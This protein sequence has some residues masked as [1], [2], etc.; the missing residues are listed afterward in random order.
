MNLNKK[1]GLGFGS[2]L[3]VLGGLV[4]F[5]QSTLASLRDGYDGMIGGEL[6]LQNDL[7]TAE[8]LMLQ[9]RRNEKDFLLRYDEK[10][11]QEFSDSLDA[12]ID[13][14]S[15]MKV[16]AQEI[17]FPE[18]VPKAKLMAEQAKSYGVAFDKLVAS[19]RRLGLDE[20]SGL[21]GQFRK[22]AHDL[23]GAFVTHRVDALYRELLFLRRWEKD[24][25]RTSSK[26]Y[27]SRLQDSIESF[28]GLLRESSFE[29]E[30]VA[31]QIASLQQY[32][33]S[34]KAYADATEDAVRLIHYGE[35]RGAAHSLESFLKHQWI[36]N[37]QEL[38]L[39]ARKHEKDFLLRKNGKYV[40]RFEAV[41]LALREGIDGSD[42]GDKGKQGLMESIHRYKEGFLA[43]VAETKS[44]T[45]LIGTLR[46]EVHALQP[47]FD[48]FA[49][50]VGERASETKL[51]V[52]E[53]A[54]WRGKL[55]M[56]LGFG[57]ILAGLAIAWS[58]G[59]SVKF[60]L[61]QTITVL[62]EI[63]EGDG[64]LTQR[65]SE[66]SKDEMGQLAR[67]FNAFAG[68]IEQA[69]IQVR[70]GCE[71]IDAGTEQL[72]QSS[73]SLANA[74]VTQ[75]ASLHDVSVSL[76]NVEA[77]A[78]SNHA[79]ASSA[80]TI[81]DRSRSTALLGKQEMDEL[82]LAMTDIKNSSEEV[83]TV[84]RLIDSIAFQTNLLALN[85]AVEAAR[86]G[87]SGKGF[88]VVAEEVRNLAQRS[89]AAAR[90]TSEMVDKAKS[91]TDKG[92][93]IVERVG[94]TLGDIIENASEISNLLQVIK[95]GSTD[96]RS[97]IERIALVVGDLN[98]ST[99][100]HAGSSEEMAASVQQTANQV[101]ILRE[102]T[103][104]FKVSER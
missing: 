9:C 17:E 12:L 98:Q 43:L 74:A 42:L 78:I 40:D 63:A 103:S 16:L 44:R 85:A 45:A 55:L 29:P 26:K 76:A 6:Q 2:V 67:W 4:G 80:V 38:L 71:D 33:E 68:K 65:I 52:L 35:V 102:I 101:S 47:L 51:S 66:Q 90:E 54:E 97:N 82:S 73:Q 20:N 7:Q 41:L 72:S 81:G 34:F 31:T 32:S 22:D 70:G 62:R 8:S 58:I 14:T 37:C 18:I 13:T 10:Y 3:V 89:A 5:G 28:G 61:F 11:T 84:I 88:A 104:Q 19:S 50:T 1:I 21:Q 15:A 49:A 100:T 27:W 59:R 56:Q 36:P 87:E 53:S 99:Q 83:E 64:D 24:Y 92:V 30:V 23:A 79:G 75:S 91:R 96:Q 95:D 60:T 86:A 77:M 93:A 94:G 25:V 69:I 48:E 39:E 46:T 57:A